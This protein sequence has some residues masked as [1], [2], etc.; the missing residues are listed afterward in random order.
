MKDKD[1]AKDFWLRYSKL[2]D[3]DLPVIIQTGIPQPT[4]STFKRMSRF[5][6]ADQA[7]RIARAL[8]TTVEFLVDGE[9][10]TRYLKE[11]FRK[12][13]VLFQPPPRLADIWEVVAALNEEKLEV[14]RPM[15]LAL[16]E[17]TP[18]EKAKPG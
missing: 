17:E 7:Y 3:K 11:L 10:G 18:A 13:G 5:P 9:E 1:K 15:V 12:E 8:N 16:G 6:R 14:L 2:T 4:L